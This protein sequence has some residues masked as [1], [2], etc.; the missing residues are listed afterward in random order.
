[1]SDDLPLK[2]T[3]VVPDR[4]SRN[5]GV[6]AED[7]HFSSQGTICRGWLFTPPGSPPYACVVL[8]HGFGADPVGPLGAIARRFAAAG[9]A[10]F[11]FDY[12][13]FGRSDGA[14]RQLLSIRKYLADWS[15]AVAYVRSR[16]DVDRARVGL[17]GSSL[18]GGLVLSVA[19]RDPELAGAVSQVPFCD[20]RSLALAA[21]LR[22]HLKTLP[23][24]LR[25]YANA[26]FGRAPYMIDGL[27]PPD[28]PAAVYTWFPATYELV[29]E[30][31]PAWRNQIAARAL[32]DMYRFRPTLEARR[33]AC[34]L[35][36]VLSYTDHVAP[37]A[38]GIRV[39]HQL[40]YAEL[41]MFQAQHFELYAGDAFER[42][43]KTE[44]QFMVH[45]LHPLARIAP[46]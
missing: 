41:A 7:C 19:A 12:R 2:P 15:A 16:E 22:H 4:K 35:L 44:V 40:P 10:A 39:A 38:P 9:I 45:H 32:I 13:H 14:P 46:A 26:A 28:A 30:R 27:G 29:R 3:P 20:G 21:G 1:V 33:I 18:S 31:A 25:D 11:A 36:V 5:G 34:P 42:A 43:L 6:A 8:A 24:V 17:W 37:P 23:A